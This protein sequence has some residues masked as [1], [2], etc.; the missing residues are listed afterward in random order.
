M[1]LPAANSLILAPSFYP[2]R[3]A[4]AVRVAMRSSEIAFCLVGAMSHSHWRR[5]QGQAA[6]ELARRGVTLSP[7]QLT[8]RSHVAIVVHYNPLR[9]S[10]RYATRRQPA[11]EVSLDGNTNWLPAVVISRDM[12]RNWQIAAETIWQMGLDVLELCNDVL[13]ERGETSTA[14]LLTVSLLEVEAAYDFAAR[15]PRAFVESRRERFVS[16]FADARATDYI[17]AERIAARSERQGMALTA[18]PYSGER[19]KLYSKTNNRV[20]IEVSMSRAALR[21]IGVRRREIDGET[22][23]F[24]I[25]AKVASHAAGVANRV[26]Q[27]EAQIDVEARANV[28]ELVV[29]LI[30]RTR[31]TEKIHSFIDAIVSSGRVSAVW[32]RHVPGRLVRDG[33]LVRQSRGVYALSE[34]YREAQ[35]AL[36]QFLLGSRRERTGPIVRSRRRNAGPGT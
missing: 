11:G 20:R 5:N 26:L 4:I 22:T 15:Y 3:I 8:E 30:K 9:Y 25:F 28:V 2:D 27:N 17:G 34:R 12:R 10:H 32:D 23:F 24:E 19:V 6:L 29:A 7:K 21:R 13:E 18:N 16:H 33:V 14:N 31:D 36:A 35:S 1:P